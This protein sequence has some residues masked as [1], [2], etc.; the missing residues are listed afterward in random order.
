M[1]QFVPMS[2]RITNIRTKRD[3]FTSGRN[4]TINSERTKI[5][6]DYY[7]AHENEYPILK[8]AGAFYTWCATRQISVF[9]DDIF[10]GTPGPDERALSPYV[11]LSC[12]WI[13]GVVNDTDESFRKAWQSSDSIYM[14]DEQRVIFREAYDFWKDKTLSKMV[15]G[16][17]TSDFWDAMGNGCILNGINNPIFQG[18]SGLP[19][20]HY[21]ANFNKVVNVGF[22]EVRRRVLEKIAARKGRVFGTAAQS[23]AFYH[24]VVR[25]CDGAILLSKRYAEGCREKAKTETGARKAELLRMAES[26]QWIMENP[27]R[28]YWE[29]LQAII[30]YQLML[31]TDAQQHGESIGRVDK[32]TGHLLQ[33]QLDGG[34]I[35]QEEAQEYSDA[36]ILRQSDIIVLPGF[37][38]DN[39][40]IVDLNAKGMSLY[41]SIYNGL[42]PTAGIAL[43]LGG[44]KAD[45]SDDSTPA[46]YCLLQTYGRMK[47]A[48]PTVALRVHKNTPDEVWRLGIESSKICGG[49]PQIQND[50]IIIKSL[51]DIGLSR[52]DACDY[53]IVGCVEPAGTGCEW[54]ACGATGRESIWNMTDV[55]LLTI[56][57]GV[58][59]GTGKTALPCKK[60]Y[61][62]ESFEE[63]REAFKAEM[64]YV[65]DWSVSYINLFEM[66]YSQYFPCIVASSMME[67]CLENG[68]D[69]TEGGAKY[70]RTGLTACGT[71]NVADSLMAIKKLCFDDKTV[72]LREMY[73]ALKNNWE[74]HEQLRQTII[75]EVPHYGNDNDEVDGL[76]T[77]ALGLFAEIMA[78]AEGARGKFSGGTFTMTAHIYLG[79]MLGATPDGRKA[80]EPIADAISPRQGF[81]KKGPTAYLRSAAKLPHRALSNGDQLNIRFSP[82]SVEGDEGAEKLKQLIK[83]Y[84]GLNGMQVQFNVV[85]TTALRE[86]QKKPDEYRDLVVRI[87]GFSTYF[88]SLDKLTQ[89]DF[90]RRTEQTI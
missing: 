25:I 21:V 46:T 12:A 44:Q 31:S 84:F 9:D 50:E 47:F 66:V 57:A 89:D 38:V 10:V 37:M 82:S 67:G 58:N 41:S 39:K 2:D 52:E 42:T 90:I 88:V 81:D 11:D 24:A 72:S 7:K 56:N 59:P 22:G 86:A 71:A 3:V 23:H 36:F 4:M 20:G 79:A 19:Q 65:L 75:N 6:T 18:V 63:F 69:V 45:G 80:G 48:D 61:E 51:M 28:S 1:F 32:Y 29:G 16:A 26:L 64:Q 40:R 77:W 60:L 55:I 78:N 30:F 33:K 43:T 87:A 15:E 62:Y 74:G 8:R 5:Y 70:N 73:D 27:A 14:S 53:S 34:T 68:R 49:V 35:T 83:A 13:P 54:P 17:L 85:S 76:A